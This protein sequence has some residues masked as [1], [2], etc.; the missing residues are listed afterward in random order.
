MNLDKVLKDVR[1]NNL[2]MSFPRS[3]EEKDSP[4]TVQN[5]LL[6]AL[7]TF[8]VRNKKEV[9]EIQELAMM[10]LKKEGGTELSDQQKKLLSD[11]L[12]EATY[13]INEKGEHKGI[14]LP[15]LVAQ[16]LEELE[17]NK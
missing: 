16:V 11:V 10:A 15:I 13:R 2:K 14:Y 8:P 3:E 6:N 7:G 1:G 12:F 9:F 17:I 4:E 5:V